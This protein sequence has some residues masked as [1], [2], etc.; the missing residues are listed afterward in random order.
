MKRFF[1]ISF[2]IL[3]TFGIFSSFAQD[4]GM[5]ELDLS[6]ATQIINEDDLDVT[7][8]HETQD[9]GSKEFFL[10][11]NIKSEIHSGKVLVNWDL[12]SGLILAEEADTP[13]SRLQLVPGD[14]KE[15]KKRV[16]AIKQ[17]KQE[18]EVTVTAI[19]ADFYYLSADKYEIE[20][21][22][23]YEIIPYSDEYKQAKNLRLA[24][25]VILYSLIFVIILATSLYS[26][27]KLNAWRN[28]P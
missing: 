14:R 2:V 18:T 20:F 26:Y 22:D 17:G 12:P 1:A 8:S 25:Q 10:I 28:E 9:P 21:N 15:V 19:K 7:L 6:G 5:E 13:V 11:A 4:E 3:L 27:K 23:K 24:G 16:R